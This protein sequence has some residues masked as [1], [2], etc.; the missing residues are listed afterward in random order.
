MP[1]FPDETLV[2][3]LAIVSLTATS[4]FAWLIRRIVREMR[5]ANNIPSLF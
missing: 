1:E 3:T 2:T 5:D 4:G